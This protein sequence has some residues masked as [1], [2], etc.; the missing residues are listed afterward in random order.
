V[1]SIGPP[2]AEPTGS[3]S[4]RR[5]RGFGPGVET[6]R[7]ASTHGSAGS[8]PAP[9]LLDTMETQLHAGTGWDAIRAAAS[10]SS[11]KLVVA[12]I[13]ACSN[14]A[15]RVMGGPAGA[16]VCEAGARWP[17]ADRP[18]WTVGTGIL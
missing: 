14:S 15:W 17:G 6:A 12:M 13:P 9:P 1:V 4:C 7:P 10:S 11:P 8:T 3:T 2:R 16:A 18:A 5:L